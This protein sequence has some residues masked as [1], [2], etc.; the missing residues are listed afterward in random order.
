VSSDNPL[1]GIRAPVTWALLSVL[2]LDSE[3]GFLALL[4]HPTLYL[5]HVPDDILG[6]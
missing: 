3:N 4:R 1:V 2:K 6:H 5:I